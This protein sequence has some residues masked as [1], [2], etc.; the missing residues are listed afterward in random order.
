VVRERSARL[1][2]EDVELVEVTLRWP[3]GAEAERRTFE[4]LFGPKLT[5]ATAIVGDQALFALG[6]DWAERLAVMLDTARGETASSVGDE[7]AFAEALAYHDRGRVSLA[8]LETGRMARFAADLIA[9]VGDLD[10]RGRAGLSSLVEHTGSGAIVSTTNAAGSRY[11]LTTHVPA[12]A[13]LASAK[14]N[15]VLWRMALSPLLDP[16]TVPPLPLPPPHLTPP[17]R[18]IAAPMGSH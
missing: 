8:Y 10:E 18:Q 6:A 3:P 9:Q 4:T 7:P 5:L 11:E 2:D 16:P 1:G 14:L 12:S 13:M 15:G 17:L